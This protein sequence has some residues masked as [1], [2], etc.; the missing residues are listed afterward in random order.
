MDNMDIIS[1]AAPLAQI[2]A[3]IGLFV[4]MHTQPKFASLDAMLDAL[5]GDVA[6]LKEQLAEASDRV[7][8]NDN[9]HAEALLGIRNEV[10]EIVT[11]A[12]DRINPIERD[13]ARLLERTGRKGC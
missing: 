2:G 6:A 3:V 13:I 12:H 9:R 10:G 7:D 1:I 11:K 4:K 5:R 8:D